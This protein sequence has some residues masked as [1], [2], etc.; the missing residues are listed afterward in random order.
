MN[1][2]QYI[3][4]LVDWGGVLPLAAGEVGLQTPRVTNVPRMLAFKLRGKTILPP[5]V[6]V[7][8][9]IL[10]PPRATANAAVVKRGEELYQRYCS[11]CHG[12]GPLGVGCCRIC[13]TPAR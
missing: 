7:K 3:A 8:A 1:G 4:I 13:A 6:G 11:G 12:D 5:V 9:P 2:A 10:T